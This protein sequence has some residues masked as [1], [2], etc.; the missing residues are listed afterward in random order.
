MSLVAVNWMV[1]KIKEIYCRSVKRRVEGKRRVIGKNRVT[2]NS[3]CRLRIFA[4]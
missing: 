1:K 3:V 4:L 2:M